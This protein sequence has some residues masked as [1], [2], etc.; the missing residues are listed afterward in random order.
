MN[1]LNNDNLIEQA[2]TEL[3]TMIN[4]S[5]SVTSTLKTI[6]GNIRINAA[7][8][9][10]IDSSVT[11]EDMN[12]E[13]YTSVKHFIKDNATLE[14]NLIMVAVREA[15]QSDDQ[16]SAQWLKLNKS[17]IGTPVKA[18]QRELNKLFPVEGKNWTF[19]N[20][21]E[22]VEVDGKTI[23]QWTGENELVLN[24]KRE[25]APSTDK[26]NSTPVEAPT[27]LSIPEQIK[28]FDNP[29][30]KD[31]RAILEALK[32]SFPM[33]AELVEIIANSDQKVALKNM[34]A[35]TK[36]AKKFNATK[37]ELEAQ[38]AMQKEHAELKSIVENLTAKQL[39]SAKKK[40]A[41]Q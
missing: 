39:Q 32:T 29:T 11:V 36:S 8:N 12:V 38:R 37:S 41:V 20:I 33:K 9:A 28:A 30:V 18:I 2:T 24:D 26:D 31:T 19:S 17:V 6:L 40:A 27:V 1:L 13:Q 22:Q 3:T 10:G 14:L 7:I 34:N 5:G 4:S 25:S 35:P 15:T 21:T 16:T 23:D